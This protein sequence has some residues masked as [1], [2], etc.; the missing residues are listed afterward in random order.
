MKSISAFLLNCHRWTGLTLGLVVLYMALTGAGLAFRTQL[1]PL[2]D[3]TLLA[4]P[5]CTPQ[6]LDGL[7]AAAREAHPDA[8]LES[9]RFNPK[10]GQTVAVHF[11][12]GV[13]VYID[14]CTGAARGQRGNF[15][16]VFGSLEKLHRMLFWEEHDLALTIVVGGFLTLMVIAGFLVWWPRR[17]MGLKINPHLQGQALLANIHRTV[18][19]YGGLILLVTASTGLMMITDVGKGPSRKVAVSEGEAAGPELLWTKASVKLS[20]P[21][22][23][24]MRLPRRKT[25]PVRMQVVE[26][27]APHSRARDELAL[28]PVSGEILSYVPYAETSPGGKFA[29]W[30]VS[31]HSGQVG[32]V[33]GASVMFLGAASVPILAYCGILLYWQRRKKS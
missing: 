11:A 32:G 16:G 14:P 25:D 1:E 7:T 17:R 15:E 6:P 30:L 23:V 13:T 24:L 20:D 12:D 10:G 18:G 5:F 33:F 28:D 29:N 3:S 2:V 31:I 8:K 4:A 21:I 26:E 19:F 22:D 27:G 9:L